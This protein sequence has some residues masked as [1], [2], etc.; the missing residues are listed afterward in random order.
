MCF[1]MIGNNTICRFLSHLAFSLCYTGKLCN[2]IS[3]HLCIWTM[4]SIIS[5]LSKEL[6]RSIYLVWDTVNFFL[7]R[8][9]L[10][11]IFTRECILIYLT[12][13]SSIFAH[14]KQ[15]SWCAFKSIY[16]PISIWKKSF[17]RANNICY[18]GLYTC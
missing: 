11:E 8:I 1:S 4:T 17:G 9:P 6:L 10:S 5:L 12:V 18:K 13:R 16:E 15:K 2:S 7:C 3:F 14:M